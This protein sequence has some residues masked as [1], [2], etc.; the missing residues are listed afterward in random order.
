MYR[1]A[2]CKSRCRWILPGKTKVELQHKGSS[3]IICAIKTGR[4]IVVPGPYPQVTMERPWKRHTVEENEPSRRRTYRQREGE[5]TDRDSS[6]WSPTDTS[7]PPG[8]PIRLETVQNQQSCSC[9]C[10]QAAKSRHVANTVCHMIHRLSKYICLT[11]ILR[12]LMKKLINCGSKIESNLKASLLVGCGSRSFLISGH[13]P[14]K[15]L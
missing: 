15:L 5:W 6:V 1:S 4:G 7:S 11:Y 12:Q 14:T 9:F 13:S 8:T 10:S 3:S 2:P